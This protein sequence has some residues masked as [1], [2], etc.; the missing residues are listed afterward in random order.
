MNKP[1]KIAVLYGGQSEEKEV[2]VRSGTNVHAALKRKGYDAVLIDPSKETIPPNIN[3]AYICLHG[4]GG[5][6]GCIQGHLTLLNIPFTGPGILSNAISMNKII[7]KQ[8]VSANGIKTP[9]FE[10]IKEAKT[11]L[12]YPFVL[13]PACTGSSIGVYLIKTEKDF[14]D[15]FN[16][17][18]KQFSDI[19]V[20][21]YIKGTEV[22]VG[23]I[24]E[25]NQLTVLP[26]LQLVTK[27]EF[28]DY[29]AKYTN[30]LTNF[31]VPAQISKTTEHK[32][33]EMAINV[34]K[35]LK[36]KSVSRIDMIID[37]KNEVYF[38]ENNTSPG[39]TDTSD[40]PAQAK[41][42]GINYDSLVE[43]IMHSA[44]L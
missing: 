44:S 13:K 4:K 3:T 22:T 43:R 14:H 1:K 23:I 11:N 31:I 35:S 21:E 29:E 38:I 40:L 2:S 7:A 18:T 34:F 10:K 37:D 15:K 12:N 28:Y 25:H 36:C 20:E 27:N 39:M 41:A 16:I 6:D 8:I 5:E 19:L 17:L 26:I 24:Q 9:K 42:A 32:V 33:K 30:G